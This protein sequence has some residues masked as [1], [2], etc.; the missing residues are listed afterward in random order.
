MRIAHWGI[1]A[2][3]LV[4]LPTPAS[5]KMLIPGTGQKI[6]KVGDDFEDPKWVYHLNLPKSSYENDEQQRLPAGISSN[7]R[8]YEGL[9]RGQPDVI[10]RVPTPD[11]GIPGSQGALL[12]GSRH[13]GVPGYPSYQNQQDDLIVDVHTRMGGPIPVSLSPN[14]VVRVYLPPWKEW[15]QRSGNSFGFRAA[16]QAYKFKYEKRGRFGGGGST[17]LED[18]WPGM[19]IYFHRGNG[20]DK[21]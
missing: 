8:W 11:G 12:M 19:F 15:E 10:K 20:K 13:T 1:L 2:C 7:G 17:K 18:Y 6:V 9:K 16:C 3:A 5:A 21:P 4:M 14:V